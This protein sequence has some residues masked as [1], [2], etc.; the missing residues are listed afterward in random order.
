VF[1]TIP[2]A[3]L[4]GLLSA[5]SPAA[6]AS[7]EPAAEPEVRR[8]VSVDWENQTEDAYAVTF[9]H[10]GALVA[11][12]NVLPCEAAGM[13]VEMV[14]TFSIGVAAGGGAP[15]VITEPAPEVIDS[16]AWPEAG[17]VVVVIGP[18]GAV[19]VEERDDRVTPAEDICP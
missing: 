5:C 9:A 4:I 17:F 15:G 11:T 18:D 16:T 2:I 1:R 12:A 6:E 19:T 10:D 13:G 7:A 8:M 14:G 3:A